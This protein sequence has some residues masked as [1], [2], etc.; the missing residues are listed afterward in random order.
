MDYGCAVFR[1]ARKSYL[2]KLEPIQNQGLRICLGAFRTSP[3]QSLYVETNEP[4]LYLRFDKLC[5]Q[6]AL[7][8]RSNPDN[9]AYDVV[10]NPQYYDLYDKK[11]ST[12]RS[13]G[14]RVEEDLSAI[15]PQLDLIQTVSLPEDPPWTIQKPHIDLFLTHEKK[16][17]G[18]DCMFQSL[19][20]ELKGYYSDHRAVFTDGSKTENRVAAAA[21]SDGLSAQVRL[22][23]NASI[24]TAEL[25]ALK[26]AFNIV[27]NCDDDRF[28]IFSDSLSSL[29]ALD[30]NNCDHPFIQDILK[31]FNDCCSVNKIV[32]LAWVPSHV[33]IKGNEKADELAKQALNF[34]VLDL[35]VPYTDLKVNVNSVFKQKWQA[36]WNACPDNKLF[37]INPTVGDFYVWTGLSRR[38]EIVI[39]RARIGH[40]YFTHSY[41]LKGEEMPWCIPCHCPDTVKHILLDCIDLRDTRIKYY[42]DINT[43]QKLFSEN[44]FSIINYLKECGLYK[45]M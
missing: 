13:F 21:T 16:H 19:F 33:G 34:N 23:G 37:Q 32:V 35:K 45:K 41:L 4:P 12:I 6:Y 29:Q 10:F 39:T 25:Q 26:M 38:E 40:T 18:D 31:L 42:R 28:I 11:P 27:K 3:M 20:A 17:L 15:C 22:P 24:F 2:K 7:K 43:M 44:V 9:P 1:S 36:Q 5:I 8:L 30:S 14:H